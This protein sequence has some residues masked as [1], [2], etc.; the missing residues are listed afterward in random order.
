MGEEYR[1]CCGDAWRLAYGVPR[2]TYLRQI[3]SDFDLPVK[4]RKLV[5]EQDAKLSPG[6]RIGTFTERE[7]QFIVWLQRCASSISEK[8]PFGEGDE[9]QLRL[10]YP[11]KITVHS[12]YR[13]DTSFENESQIGSPLDYSS[14]CRVW[15]TCPDLAHIKLMKHKEGFAKCSLCSDYERAITGALTLAQREQWDTT[16]FNHIAETKR[17][18]AQYYKSRLKGAES[19]KLDPVLGTVKLL[20]TALILSIIIDAMDQKKTRI[21][22]F[23]RPDKCIGSD[24]GLQCKLFGA[25]VH[26]F[27]T[28][29]FWSTCQLKTGTNLTIEVLRRTLIKIHSEFGFLPPILHLQ[30]DNASDN[31]SRLFLAFIAYLVQEGVFLKVKLTY[32]I[33]GHTHE[34]I[35]QYFSVISRYFKKVIMSI[36]SI[37]GFL[38]A[39]MSCFKTRGCIPRCVE[40]IRYYFDCSAL[41]TD[42]LD[43]KLADFDPSEKTGRKVHHF[44]FK[45][46]DE[47]RAVMTY[48]LK[49]SNDAVYPR[50]YDKGMPFESDDHGTGLVLDCKP[51]KDQLTKEK[52]WT[53]TVEFKNK[54]G[55]SYFKDITHP[56]QETFWCSHA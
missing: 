52:F 35:D 14:C 9:V 31:K 6:Q 27:G 13:S 49:R 19:F 21:P 45:R 56:A 15:K 8:M 42:F 43:K 12:I 23:A 37:V 10:P 20:A 38:T 51:L 1:Q 29:L 4:K 17:E 48:K 47:G 18:R 16:Y 50:Q 7:L 28:F 33:V 32:L 44:V 24:Y 40:Q 11:N 46:N 36:F 39:L 5:I 54:D 25:M 2:N 34:D 30:L 41:D 53:Y 26:G 3:S 55:S 22:Y